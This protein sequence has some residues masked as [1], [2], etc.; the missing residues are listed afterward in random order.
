[1]LYE[2]LISNSE[3]SIT[4]SAAAIAINLL[5]PEYDRLDVFRQILKVL[6]GWGELGLTRLNLD[7]TIHIMDPEA[8]RIHVLGPG[9]V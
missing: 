9:L 5:E 2:V 3:D 7:E 8:L 4:A 6:Q 1:M